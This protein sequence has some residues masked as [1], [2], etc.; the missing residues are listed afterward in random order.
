MK[1][2]E[3]IIE[4][5]A[6]LKDRFDVVLNN[7]RAENKHPSYQ[8][9]FVSAE[10]DAFKET[11]SEKVDDLPSNRLVVEELDLWI[12][13]LNDKKRRLSRGYNRLTDIYYSYCEKLVIELR[14]KK[15]KLSKEIKNSTKKSSDL[16]A[17]DPTDRSDF[18]R[19]EIALVGRFLSEIGFF[20]KDLNNSQIS[21]IF[22]QLTGYSASQIRQLMSKGEK[23]EKEVK[24]EQLTHLISL[25]NQFIK[26]L[27]EEKGNLK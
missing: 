8:L 12:K 19:V 7:K 25:L 1:D 6:E 10:Y 15:N 5:F 23:Y 21:D 2:E 20:R 4:I 22:H 13:E 24:K 14:D 18:S 17:L 3:F 27:Q 16:S 26:E 9:A 11:L